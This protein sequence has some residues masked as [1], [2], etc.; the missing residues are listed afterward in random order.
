MRWCARMLLLATVRLLDVPY[1]ADKDY[2][3]LV[4]E[5][6][7]PLARGRI[8]LV[9]FGAGNRLSYAVLT[10]LRTA[11]KTERPLK[12]IY[13]A[14][15]EDYRITEEALR[16]CFF[17]RDHTLCSVGDAVRTA[18]PASSLGLLKEVYRA[19]VEAP[20]AIKSKK[21]RLLS[22]LCAHPD[23]TRAS[24]EEALGTD[25]VKSALSALCREG[26]AERVFLQAPPAAPKTRRFY[27]L[28]VMGDE[29]RALLRGDSPLR[30]KSR[31][32]CLFLDA[33]GGCFESEIIDR[34]NISRSPLDTLVKK[35]SS[36]SRKGRSSATPILR[37][38]AKET[39]TPSSSLA[40]RARRM[41]RQWRFMK[42]R[43]LLAF[44]CTV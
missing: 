13:A 23:A 12:E 32:V 31:A 8:L 27:T 30:E 11:E 6:L 40:R 21:D 15:P 38:P 2:D 28:A 33:E 20:I 14:L 5:R 1:S 19:K 35:G 34:L 10:A 17:L 25:S 9:P 42:K 41:R 44:F 26:C 3:Y 18:F 43:S 36:P 22:Y 37:F 7:P 29:R 39:P 4:P 16:L 24:L